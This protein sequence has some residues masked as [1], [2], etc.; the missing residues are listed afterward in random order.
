[1]ARLWVWL[2]L[3][4]VVGLWAGVGAAELDPDLL[5]P[6]DMD[7]VC[8]DNTNTMIEYSSNHASLD[9][10]GR[11]VAFARVDPIADLYDVWVRDR[12][13]AISYLIS[14][15]MG[16]NPLLGTSASG[17]SGEPVISADG[18]LVAFTS[19]A[20][21]LVTGDYNGVTDIFVATVPPFDMERVSVTSNGWEARGA[22]WDPEMSPDGRYVVFTSEAANLKFG[23]NNGASDVFLRDRQ[24]GITELISVNSY[25]VIGNGASE[26]AD[27]SGDGRYVVFTSEATNLVPDDTNGVKD[28]FVRDRVANTTTRITHSNWGEQADRESMSPS[29]SADGR[30]IAYSS[31]ATNQVAGDHNGYWDIYVYD[32]GVDTTERASVRAYGAEGYGDCFN[33]DL[34]YAGDWVFFD[35]DAGDL[36]PSYAPGGYPR[37]FVRMRSAGVTMAVDWMVS[38]TTGAPVIP[39]AACWA[40]HVNLM[41]DYL[42]FDSY[43]GNL[44][45]A[46]LSPTAAPPRS[47]VIVR[48]I[49]DGRT[50]ADVPTFYW[51]YREIQDLYDW[52]IVGGYGQVFLPLD[53]VTRATMAVTIA[54]VLCGGDPNVPNAAGP[55]QFP[56]VPP[57]HWAFKYVEYVY[58]RDIIRGYPDGNFDP[59]GEVDRAMIAV[60]MARAL[61]GGDAGVPVGP[62][63]PTF[64]DLLPADPIYGYA[65]NYVE[66]LVGRGV[67]HGFSDGRYRPDLIITRDQMCVYL[68]RTFYE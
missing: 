23:D 3:A 15:A 42:A 49:Y 55:G 59:D 64:P 57:T 22:S 48:T 19:S 25:G 36:D 2:W 66:Y 37:V 58:S 24:L 14:L 46:P 63:T 33:P 18:T 8:L 11:N 4:A 41:R 35:S 16:S 20:Y 7:F 67:V 31:L 39:E 28:I 1:M 12:G 5:L 45:D 29:I 26:Q 62:P 65:Y 6:T 21:N 54:R 32:R 60:F 17:W 56:D 34:D 9:A 44:T 53:P 47:G 43:A 61:C 38:P 10:I 52:Q 27:V 13:A 50:F 40:P 51:A 68:H 30:V